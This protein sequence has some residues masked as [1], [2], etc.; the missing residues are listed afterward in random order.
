MYHRIKFF[1]F[2]GHEC[3]VNRMRDIYHTRIGLNSLN[4]FGRFIYRMNNTGIAFADKIVEQM[5]ANRC[6]VFTGT[7]NSDTLWIEH[8]VKVFQ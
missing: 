4:P 1:R 6:F 2:G 5:E 8:C 7:N 3:Q